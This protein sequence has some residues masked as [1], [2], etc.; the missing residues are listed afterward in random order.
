MLVVKRDGRKEEWNDEKIVAAIS[1]AAY[2]V[3]ETIS[4]FSSILQKIETKVN[5]LDNTVDITILHKA[6]EDVLMGSKY[7]NVARAYI[8]K[9]SERDKERLQK[10]KL[11]GA[12]ESVINQ[13]NNDLKKDNGNLDT[14]KFSS[15][16]TLMVGELSREAAKHI[17]PQ[18]IVEAHEQGIIH[19]HDITFSPALPISNCCLVDLKG[20]L[21]NGFTLG[22]ADIGTPNSIGVATA[23]TAQIISQVSSDQYGGTSIRAIDEV[24]APYVTKSFNKHLANAEK[25]NVADKHQYATALTEKETFDA[26]QALEYEVN[27]LF[28]SHAQ[29]PFSTISIGTGTSWESRLIQKCI[30]KVRKDGFGVKKITAIFPKIIFV[31][32]EG[33]N[34]KPNDPNYDIKRLALE[35]SSLRLYPDIISA[36]N[37]KLITGAST[38]VASMGKQQLPM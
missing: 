14:N 36:K 27:S 19:F 24:L 28:N 8:S 31:I 26:F 15:Q 25:Y 9:R 2:E 29:T 7:K 23:V 11:W 4:D 34:L 38:P 35:C 37:N 6:V 17:L 32:E 1:K 3:G 21:E 5:K 22:A 33:V 30:L 20:M 10:T 13:T 16:R 18:H 12:V